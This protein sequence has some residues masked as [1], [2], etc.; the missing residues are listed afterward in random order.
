LPVCLVPWNVVKH[1]CANLL[2]SAMAVPPA[3]RF[4]LVQWFD[5]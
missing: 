1:A 5:L 4:S 2:N 3:D